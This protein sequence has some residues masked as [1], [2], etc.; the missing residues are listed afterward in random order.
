[1]L[2][3][4]KQLQTVLILKKTLLANLLN[5]LKM[6]VHGNNRVGTCAI[7]DITVFGRIAGANAAQGK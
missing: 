5:V 6:G 1:M 7:T 2:S 4:I 3:T